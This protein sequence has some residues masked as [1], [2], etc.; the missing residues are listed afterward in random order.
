MMLNDQETSI[1]AE[2]RSLIFN[3][4]DTWLVGN[5]DIPTVSCK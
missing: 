5:T 2:I 4:S 3:V 1:I